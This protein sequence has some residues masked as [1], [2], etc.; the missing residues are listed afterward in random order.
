MKEMDEW[1]QID[2]ADVILDA[3]LRP[4]ASPTVKMVLTVNKER[5]K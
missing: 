5:S 1:R 4:H 2:V 3:A